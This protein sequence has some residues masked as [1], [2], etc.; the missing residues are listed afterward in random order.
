MKV[1]PN[2]T[3]LKKK[4]KTQKNDPIKLAIDNA[5]NHNLTKDDIEKYK[6]MLRMQ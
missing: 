4:L 5:K 1:I 3:N 2:Y 6:R